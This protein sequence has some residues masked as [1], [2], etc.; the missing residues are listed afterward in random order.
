MLLSPAR[1]SPASGAFASIR[2]CWSREVHEAGAK[3]RIVLGGGNV[4]RD[5]SAAAEAMDRA[6]ADSIGVLASVINGMAR[7]DAL[8][9]EG[10]PRPAP[11]RPR[12]HAPRPEPDVR[13]KSAEGDPSPREGGRS[14]FLR[15]GRAIRRFYDGHGGGAR[16]IEIQADIVLKATRVDG[17]YSADPDEDSS[18]GATTL[19]S[20]EPIQRGSSDSWTRTALALCREDDLPIMVFEMDVPGNIVKALRGE[21]VG[22]ARPARTPRTRSAPERARAAAWRCRNGD[23]A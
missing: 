12:D 22:D 14:S 2:A 10:V 20:A 11:E 7:Q 1:D 8:E 15:P 16:A 13:G 3:A 23:R 4:I 9:R 5:M 17:V 6:Q 18:D 21:R 19:R